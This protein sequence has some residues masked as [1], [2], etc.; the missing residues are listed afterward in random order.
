MPLTFDSAYSATAVGDTVLFN[1]TV[2]EA[3]SIMLLFNS[4]TAAGSVYNTATVRY[5]TSGTD[6]TFIGQINSGSR[7]VGCWYILNPATGTNQV[8]MAFSSNF[9]KCGAV[10]IYKAARQSSQPDASSTDSAASEATKNLAITVGSPNSWIVGAW[11]MSS[12]TPVSGTTERIAQAD[13][14]SGVTLFVGDSDSAKATGSQSLEYTGS[15]QEWAGIIVSIAP[16]VFRSKII[17]FNET[18]I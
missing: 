8:E 1:A 5:P 3:D 13:G 2:A 18:F 15:A 7:T 6:A 12:G 10:A 17:S 16:N 14:G 4:N 11:A 9:D